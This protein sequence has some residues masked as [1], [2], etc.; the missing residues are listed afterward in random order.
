[1]IFDRLFKKSEEKNNEPSLIDKINL[2][3]DLLLQKSSMLNNDY[4]TEKQ[5]IVD[6]AEEAKAFKI[7]DKDIFSA[8]LEQEI[9]GKITTASSACEASLVGKGDDNLKEA[10]AS[11]KTVINQRTALSK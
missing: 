4:E 3:M 7:I 10:V 5:L 9:L 11:L 2:Y 8:K 6:L 1:M